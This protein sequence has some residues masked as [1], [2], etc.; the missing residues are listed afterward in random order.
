MPWIIDLIGF[1][2]SETLLGIETSQTLFYFGDRLT[3]CFKASETLLGIETSLAAFPDLYTLRF[4]ASETLLG[5]E[6]TSLIAKRTPN[7]TAS[8]P[9]KPF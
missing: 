8:K 5:I 9:L 4:K 7:A 3:E 6:T 1:K 2:A